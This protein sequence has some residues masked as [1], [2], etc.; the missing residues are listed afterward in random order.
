MITRV[1]DPPKVNSPA[2]TSCGSEHIQIERCRTGPHFS[3]VACMECGAKTWGKT[4]WSPERAR[5]FVL[6]FGKFRGV[7]IGELST[8]E[9]GRSYLLWLSGNAEGNAAIAAAIVLDPASETC[10]DVSSPRKKNSPDVSAPTSL[11]VDD[12]LNEQGH[13]P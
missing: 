6:H 8:T 12:T 11:S 2:C 5:N 4:P 9:E 7:S 1:L 10:F 13:N 3:V